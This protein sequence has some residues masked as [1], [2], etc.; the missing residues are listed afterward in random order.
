MQKMFKMKDLGKLRHFLG[1][2]F[3]HSDGYITMSQKRKVS[4]VLQRF[5]MQNC[6]SR[7][8]PCDQKLELTEGSVKMSDV[9]M[10]RETAGS[11]IYLSKST[12]PDLS[13]CM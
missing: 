5:N 9:R 7:E 4:K 11:L 13:Y 10:Y 12:R 6:R 1:I 2:E 3:I 8:T